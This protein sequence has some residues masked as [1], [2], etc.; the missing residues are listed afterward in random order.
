MKK[1]GGDVKGECEVLD[2]E[3]KLIGVYDLKTGIFTDNQGRKFQRGYGGYLTPEKF[4][5]LDN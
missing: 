2:K 1:H 4:V 3:K 5:V